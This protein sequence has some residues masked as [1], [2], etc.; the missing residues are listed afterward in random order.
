MSLYKNRLISST[1]LM[2]ERGQDRLEG[3]IC[4]SFPWVPEGQISYQTWKIYHLSLYCIFSFSS[5]DQQLIWGEF[6]EP[7]IKI[8]C[9]KVAI[10]SANGTFATASQRAGFPSSHSIPSLISSRSDHILNFWDLWISLNEKKNNVMVNDVTLKQI[11]KG[12][13]VCSVREKARL[14]CFI[15]GRR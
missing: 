8:L 5:W 14:A 4:L 2:V 15:F 3:G 7:K 9:S 10:T 12:S 13:L 6:P 1:G 11:K